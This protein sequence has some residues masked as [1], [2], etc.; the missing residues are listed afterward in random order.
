ML[1]CRVLPLRLC[2][3]SFPRLAFVPRRDLAADL[4]FPEATPNSV[5]SSS[6]V[7]GRLGSNVRL[8]NGS[9]RVAK[10]SVF[11]KTGWTGGLPMLTIAGS[12]KDR[13]WV[14]CSGSRDGGSGL[15]ADSRGE[16]PN[17]FGTASLGITSRSA[18]LLLGI[19]KLSVRRC[20]A[21]Q[22]T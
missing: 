14:S 18:R 19:W 6:D 3:C 21:N 5:V 20:D 12:T 9:L 7:S 17:A 15:G 16:W 10:V 1:C 4:V 2:W 8:S 13:S 22:K 11:F